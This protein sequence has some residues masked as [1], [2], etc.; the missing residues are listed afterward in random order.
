M[1][2][3]HQLTDAPGSAVDSS[4][5][6]AIALPLPLREP[7]P[8]GTRNLVPCRPSLPPS[9]TTIQTT[10]SFWRAAR[11]ANPPAHASAS[12]S[13]KFWRDGRA[14]ISQTRNRHYLG[15][16]IAGLRPKNPHGTN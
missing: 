9:A 16:S 12:R 5:A 4:Q 8:A 1:F 11:T 7:G 6:G 2:P 3:A 15:R 14:P 13:R 10:M